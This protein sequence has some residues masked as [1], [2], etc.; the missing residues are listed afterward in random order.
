MRRG[1]MR[2]RREYFAFLVAVVMIV[3]VAT[4]GALVDPSD[5]ETTRPAAN[6]VDANLVFT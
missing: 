1:V 6:A 5:H 2:K 3:S 4:A